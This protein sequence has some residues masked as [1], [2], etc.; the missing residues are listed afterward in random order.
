MRG[1]VLG[2]ADNR[3]VIVTADERRF[4]FT[5]EN[6][7]E[8]EPPV[9]GAQ[10]DFVEGDGIADDIY[11]ALGAAPP[12]PGPASGPPPAEGNPG[13]A[14]SEALRRMGAGIRAFPQ[15]TVAVL[16]LFIFLAI[17]YASIGSEAGRMRGSGLSV[18]EYPTLL[19]L[20]D[21]LSPLR[22]QVADLGDQLERRR[23]S[24]ASST[25]SAPGLPADFRAQ[26]T[27]ELDR[28]SA[29]QSRL[30]WT[31]TLAYLFWLIPLLAIA[32]IVLRLAGRRALAVASSVGLGVLSLVA[33]FYIMLLEGSVLGLL[34]SDLEG[35]AAEARR[36]MRREIGRAFDLN[37][38][39]WLIGLLGLAC[40]VL[41]FIPSRRLE[42]G[43]AESALPP[44]A[45]PPAQP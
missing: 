2:Y 45:E 23:D 22:E 16:I 44:P 34:E 27:R 14:A 39:G 20:N 38:G 3:G 17:S 9:R 35:P 33:A 5:G 19:S 18:R 1:T 29:A 40:I 24:L 13:E 37:L 15:L 43:A 41:L 31:L 10:V 11:L 25:A 21:T 8:P 28:Q 4:S 12:A 36:E 7:R 30:S 26:Q 32:V 6:W 42:A